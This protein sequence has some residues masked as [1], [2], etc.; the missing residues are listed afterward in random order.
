MQKTRQSYDQRV[1][2]I[3]FWR[4]DYMDVIGWLCLERAIYDHM[5]VGGRAKHDYRDIVGRAMQDA[6]AED[7]RAENYVLDHGWS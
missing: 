2:L 5:D 4:V 7:A 1:S 3:G 6:K